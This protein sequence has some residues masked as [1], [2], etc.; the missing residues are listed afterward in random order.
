[1]DENQNQ[2]KIEMVS[3]EEFEKVVAERDELLQFKP[4]ELS[5]EEKALQTKQQELWQK[6]VSLSLKE[7]GLEQFASVLKVSDEKELK[8]VIKSLTQIVNDIKAS[9]GYVPADHAKTDE[10]SKFEKEKNVAGMIGVKLS[11]LFS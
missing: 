10:Y 3:K 8:E 5:E 7:A 4:K 9:T 11:K 6:E 1:M 2:Q